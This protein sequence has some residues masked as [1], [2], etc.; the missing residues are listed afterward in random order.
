MSNNVNPK[1]CLFS[2]ELELNERSSETAKTA[3]FSMVARSGQPINHHFWGPIVHD[4]EGAQFKKRIPID[5]NHDVN[6]IVGF[7]NKISVDENGNL[8]IDGFL[9]PYK[10]NDRATEILHKAELGVPWEASI[11]FAG[12]M[13]LE[14]FEDGETVEVNGHEFEGPMT[15]VREWQL[16]GVAITPYGYDSSTST[17]FS[18]TSSINITYINKENE[19][20]KNEELNAEVTE[21]VAVDAVELEATEAEVTE[22]VAVDAE[23]E[24]PAEEA[25]EAPEAPEA[26]ELAEEAPEAAEELAEEAPE[27]EL[28]APGQAFMSLFGETE[29]AVYFAK[30]ISLDEA[31]DL[32]ITRLRSENEEL[33]SRVVEVATSGEENPV[34]FSSPDAKPPMT[35]LPV[36]IQS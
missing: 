6:E 2:A 10:E 25:P 5:F 14:R 19:D 20:M 18:D 28:E 31:K 33:R 7:G 21:E 15:V 12:D 32:E 9:T 30:G 36:S 29:G 3:P 17:Q 34:G 27:A 23:L 24:A 22:E 16:R 1:D 35:G 11:N 8:S 13:V 4:N 26:E